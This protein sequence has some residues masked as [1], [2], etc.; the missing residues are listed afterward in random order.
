MKLSLSI[1]TATMAVVTVTARSQKGKDTTSSR[2]RRYLTEKGSLWVNEPAS[3]PAKGQESRD[4]PPGSSYCTYLPNYQCYKNGWPTCCGSGGCPPQPP[5]CDVSTPSPTPPKAKTQS[6]TK[7]QEPKGPPPGSSYCTYSPN[8]QCY[9]NGW[10][11]CCGS[12]GCPPQ[13]PPCDVSTPNPTPP[14][15]K[16][17]SPTPTKSRKGQPTPSPT[18]KNSQKQ[19]KSPTRRP[20]RRP[21]S[22]PTQRHFSNLRDKKCVRDE[23]PSL[24]R[25][26]QRFQFNLV[27]S[28]AR[29][30]DADGDLYE[31]G[32]F[33]YVYSFNDC[34]DACVYNAPTNLID[35]GNFQGIDFDCRYNQCRCLYNEGTLNNRNSGGFDS[36]SRNE[37]GYGPVTGAKRNRSS[38]GIYC[39]KLASAEF[40][41]ADE[42]LE[43]DVTELWKMKDEGFRE[44]ARRVP[45]PSPVVSYPLPSIQYGTLDGTIPRHKASPTALNEVV[46]RVAFPGEPLITVVP[47]VRPSSQYVSVP[48]PPSHSPPAVPEPYYSSPALNESVGRLPFQRKA[49][50]QK[51]TLGASIPLSSSQSDH[52]RFDQGTYAHEPSPSMVSSPNL[53]MAQAQSPI[54][55]RLFVQ[56]GKQCIL[57]QLGDGD[58][59]YQL[60][61]EDMNNATWAF[62]DRPAR[63]EEVLSTKTFIKTSHRAFESDPPNVA[64]TFVDVDG[65]QHG[66]L[67]SIF[68]GATYEEDD[69]GAL[70]ATYN[71]KQ[72]SK[73]AN[74]VSIQSFFEAEESHVE[75]DDCSLFIDR[76]GR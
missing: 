61:V 6:P 33:D 40:L 29:C 68:V 14:K 58:E 21:T 13:Q 57:N 19:T 44:H 75:F 73:Q 63:N 48:R 1:A 69:L 64:V 74:I 59:E 28:N 53:L 2:P 51:P 35:S 15:G 17:H 42:L 31:Y 36:T 41:G 22:R 27:E 72:S 76:L 65:G 62:A 12:V 18:A 7:G 49:S 11:S 38:R 71:M 20:T 56:M 24:V 8:Y 23:R 54:A 66:P 70:T 67:V 16:T 47:A 45:A 10:P 4:S 37:Y 5:P 34:A 3:P 46:G 43:A 30:V 32:Q 52:E 25:N 39:G 26:G 55:P 50:A 9:M 60:V